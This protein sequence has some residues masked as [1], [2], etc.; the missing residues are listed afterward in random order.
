[1]AISSKLCYKKLNKSHI[2]KDHFK[3]VKDNLKFNEYYGFDIS[4]IDK[5]IWLSEPL[6]NEVNKKFKIKDCA[7]LKLNSYTNYKWHKDVIRGASI[8]MLMTPDAKSYT[9]FGEEKSEDQIEFIKL[10]Y[11]SEYFYL[12]NTQMIHSVF[13]L[14]KTRYIFSVE[15]EKNKNELTYAELYNMI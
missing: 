1:M 8:N 7:Y 9:L 15:F 2:I 13:N 5:D 3:S 11:E 14:D 10:D 6:L 12:F 4:L